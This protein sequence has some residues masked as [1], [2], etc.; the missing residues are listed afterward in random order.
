M[1]VYFIEYHIQ[2]D[3]GGYASDFEFKRVMKCQVSTKR[4][5]LPKTMVD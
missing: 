2:L 3:C 1:K 5:R 4:K